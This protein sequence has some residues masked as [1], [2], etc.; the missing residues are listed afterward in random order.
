[1]RLLISKHN[2]GKW[3]AHYVANKI[4]AFKP[5]A[6]KPFVLGLPTGSTP[7]D[8][9]NELIRLNKAGEVS[10]EHVVT[11]NM[12]EYVGLA[13]SHPE[14][15]HYYMHH[16]FFDHINIQAKN[17]HILNGNA[18]DLD[19]ECEQYEA[20]IAAVG[21]IHLQLGGVGED[22]H[23]AFNEPGSSLASKT[24]S[25]DL[26]MSTV[27]ANSRFFDGDINK[28]PRLALTIGID[29]VMQAEEVLIMVKGLAKAPAVFQAIE[30]SVSSMCPITA[31]QYH[32]KT[33]I[34]CDE[35]ATYE[36]R[37]KT[38]KYFENMYDDY[39]AH[40]AAMKN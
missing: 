40:D 34:L 9:Y 15:Y 2:L 29:T 1:M 33:L 37:V 27:I 4:N 22:G 19:L 30:G 26:N 28:T 21:G 3:A 5:T 38:I 23:L 12:D 10:F 13:E 16:Y 6:D 31:L 18:A 25:K 24:R 17:I 8:M 11:F 7:L 32:R 20:A 14:S 35:L 39:A 36:L